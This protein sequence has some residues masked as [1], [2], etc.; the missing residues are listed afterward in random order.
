MRGHQDEF[1]EYRKYKLGGGGK[2]MVSVSDLIR[3]L[4]DIK[5]ESDRIDAYI[6]QGKQASEGNEDGE[7][8]DSSSYSRQRR[9]VKGG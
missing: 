2:A 9:C 1:R 7:Q 3:V 5:Q 4:N 6:T 8:G